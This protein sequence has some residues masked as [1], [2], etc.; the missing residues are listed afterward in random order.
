MPNFTKSI[1]KAITENKL[2]YSLGAVAATYSFVTFV[3]LGPQSSFIRRL[4]DLNEVFPI[5][6]HCE[7][8]YENVREV[9]QQNLQ[10]GLELGSSFCAYVDGKCVVEIYGG[11]HDKERTKQYDTSSLQLVF[12]SGKTIMSVLVAHLVDKGLIDLNKSVADY[13]PEF[14]QNGKEKVLV[15]ELLAHRGG[16][17][18]L[19]TPYQ[20]TSDDLEDLDVTAKKIAQQPHNYDGRPIHD[21]HALT[22]DW[23]VNELVRRVTGKSAGQIWRED[24]N[25]KLGTEIYVG[26]PQELYPR[27][28]MLQP[29]PALRTLVRLLLPSWLHG[30]PFPKALHQVIRRRGKGLFG[31]NFRIPGLS[32]SVVDPSKAANN[33]KFMKGEGPSYATVTN[34][35]S[36]A[37]LGAAMLNGSLDGFDLISISETYNK[38]YEEMDLQEDMSMGIKMPFTAC[39][40]NVVKDTSVPDPDMDE[41][42]RVGQYR[43]DGERWHGWGGL[44]GSMIYWNVNQ[45]ISI[46]YAESQLGLV[47]VGE[48]RSVRLCDAVYKCAT[49]LKSKAN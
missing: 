34:A 14:A 27:V 43:A 19:D 40:F 12:S 39:G 45:N 49:A 1:V 24:I 44:G 26:L 37:K 4:F 31:L 47:L 36:M 10:E 35:K 9:F 5:T 23:Y 41:C 32:S 2:A 18:W 46:G 16:V 25:P 13:W 11:Y 17:G 3:R 7:P 42:E 28:A 20:I 33:Y 15:K 29:Y 30:Q 48:T 8:G 22:R 21:Y 38:V 6:A